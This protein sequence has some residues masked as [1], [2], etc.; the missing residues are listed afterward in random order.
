MSSANPIM[1]RGQIMTHYSINREERHFG[2]LFMAYLLANA[3]FRKRTFARLNSITCTQLAADDFDIYAEVAIFR[4][5]WNNLGNHVE[6]DGG[7][8]A[9]RRDE[10]GKLLSAMDIEP[11]CIDRERLFWTG[12]VG[13][14]KLWFPGRWSAAKIK[15][16]ETRCDIADKRFWRCRWLCNAKPD[17]MIHSGNAVVFIEVKVES[18]KGTNHLGYDQQQTQKDLIEVGRQMIGWMQHAHPLPV[19]LTHRELDHGMTWGHVIE[20]FE[21]TKNNGDVSAEMIARHFRHMPKPTS[22]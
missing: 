2:F 5:L 17:I 15:D 9:A 6:Y 11:A 3:E 7:L 20:D 8:N 18:G 13:S 10:L 21:A 12:E 14:S 19:A 16:L 1:G 4:D 22:K